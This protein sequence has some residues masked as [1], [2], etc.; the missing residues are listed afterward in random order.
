MKKY[1][2][3]EYRLKFL[4]SCIVLT[5]FLPMMFPETVIHHYS[6]LPDLVLKTPR[7]ELFYIPIGFLILLA[8]NLIWHE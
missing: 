6:T 1:L 2:K 8:L 4:L 5:V 7:L 3:F